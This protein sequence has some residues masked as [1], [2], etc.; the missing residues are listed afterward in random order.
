MHV[1]KDMICDVIIEMRLSICKMK[2]FFEKP[3]WGVDSSYE[4]FNIILFCVLLIGTLLSLFHNNR[5]AQVLEVL[6]KHNSYDTT[7]RT[8]HIHQKSASRI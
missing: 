8:F 4:L 2:V 6:P 7:N 5:C 3:L 1:Y